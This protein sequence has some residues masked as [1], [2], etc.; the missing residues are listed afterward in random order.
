[1]TEIFNVSIPKITFRDINKKRIV[2]LISLYV[3]LLMSVLA[4]FWASNRE[5]INI[6]YLVC[7][8]VV[9]TGIAAICSSSIFYFVSFFANKQWTVTRHFVIAFFATLAVWVCDSIFYY[10]C[11]NINNFSFYRTL[12]VHFIVTFLIGTAISSAGFFWIRN[13]YLHPNIQIIE[14]QDDS[15]ISGLL[16]VNTKQKM[17]TL[18]CNSLKSSLTLFPHELLYIESTGNYVQIY[19]TIENKIL[20]KKLRATLSNMEDALS[21]YQFMVRCHR[22][23]IV[24]LLHIRE[25]NQSKIWLN[26]LENEIPISKTY[27]AGFLKKLDSIDRLSL[28]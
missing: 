7:F 16:K 5:N 15:Q 19:Y 26:S 22:A 24:N 6:S 14:Q 17:I 23:F 9:Y 10:L 25:I 8:V 28:I 11:L 13:K 1:M 18:Y 21:G 4:S 20:H 2:L 12:E 27:K 3:F